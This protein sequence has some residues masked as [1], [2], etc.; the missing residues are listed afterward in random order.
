MCRAT[1]LLHYMTYHDTTIPRYSSNTTNRIVLPSYPC[2]Y[3]TQTCNGQPWGRRHRKMPSLL[4]FAPWYCTLTHNSGITA[5]R[6]ACAGE[7]SPSLS[8]WP[9]SITCLI[10]SVGA[11]NPL[12]VAE[13]LGQQLYDFGQSSGGDDARFGESCRNE[14][15]SEYEACARALAVWSTRERERMWKM[16][17]SWFRLD[18]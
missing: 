3:K 17:P 8:R 10:E 5:T 12:C 7:N 9:L 11:R 2:R 1:C 6:I 4:S 16:I 15:A 14:E 18:V 13:G